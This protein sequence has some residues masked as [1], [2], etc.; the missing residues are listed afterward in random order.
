MTTRRDLLKAMFATPLV[1][2]FVKDAVPFNTARVWFNDIEVPDVVSVTAHVTQPTEVYIEDN[3][4]CHRPAGL[5]IGEF[6]VVTLSDLNLDEHQYN[7]ALC[8]QKPLWLKIDNGEEAVTCRAFVMG[9][10]ID[11]RV[12]GLRQITVYLKSTGEVKRV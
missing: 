1:A 6:E 5:G 7:S 9:V 12:G 2:P 8:S 10:D 4:E 3:W 11:Q